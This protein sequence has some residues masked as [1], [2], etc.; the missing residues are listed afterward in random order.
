MPSLIDIASATEKVADVAVHALSG[1]DIADLLSRYPDLRKAVSGVEISVDALI[2]TMP[3]AVA[4]VIAMATMSR[5]EKTVP[6]QV[7]KNE[8]AASELAVGLQVDM[9]DAIIRLSLPSGITPF[10]ERLETLSAGLRGGRG[11]AL[12]TK[13]PK[14][15]KS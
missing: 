8:Q 7:K 4:A 12:A 5:S 13:S 11:A 2:A 9:L 14:P 10:M 3:D 6:E 1:A 15:S